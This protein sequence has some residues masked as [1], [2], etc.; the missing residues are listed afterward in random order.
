M[1]QAFQAFLQDRG[2][3]GRIAGQAADVGPYARCHRRF[4]GNLTGIPGN[5]SATAMAER[6]QSKADCAG[7]E[8]SP[9]ARAAF[10]AVLDLVRLLARLAAR[11]LLEPRK[12]LKQ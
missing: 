6:P 9:A 4:D 12:E 3:S 7:G 8:P 11:E 2:W 10:D 1:E 5:R